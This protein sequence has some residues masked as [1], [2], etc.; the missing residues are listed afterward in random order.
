VPLTA[1][2]ALGALAFGHV[3]FGLTAA[4]VVGSVPAVLVGSLLSSR[5]PDRFIRPAITFV[6]FA[7]GLKYV[8]V[9]TYA[10]GWTMGAVLLAGAVYWLVWVRTRPWRREPARAPAETPANLPV[11]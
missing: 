6:I 7:S 3:E 11:S 8:G 4:I 1:A 9:G 10:L 2:A 5:A